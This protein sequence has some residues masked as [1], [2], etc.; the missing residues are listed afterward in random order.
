M[1]ED[2]R[3]IYPPSVAATATTHNPRSNNGSDGTDYT[4]HRNDSLDRIDRAFPPV[5]STTHAGTPLTPAITEPFHTPRES[6]ERPRPSFD[7]P[8]PS[9]DRLRSSMDRTRSSFEQSR[10]FT[11]AAL[12]ARVESSQSTGEGRQGHGASKSRHDI[13][14]G[15]R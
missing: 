11:S 6:F 15:L 7:R 1:S 9:F 5:S 10:D 13:S 12:L 4:N 14:D 2:M 3:P 8:R